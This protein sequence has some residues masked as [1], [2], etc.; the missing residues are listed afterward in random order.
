MEYLDGGTLHDRLAAPAAWMPRTR[1]EWLERA[2]YALDQAHALGSSRDVSPRTCSRR[3][4]DVT[5]FGIAS[6]GGFDTLTLPGTVLGTAGY[7][8]PE[9]AQGEPATPASDLYGLGVVAFELLTGRRP[10]AAETAATEAFAHVNAPVPSALVRQALPAGLGAV[11]RQ[12]LARPR[13][14]SSWRTALVARRGARGQARGHG[15]RPPVVAPATVIDARVVTPADTPNGGLAETVLV[16]PRPPSSPPG[17]R[18][19]LLSVSRATGG[20]GSHPRDP[21]TAAEGSR[22][23]D[24]GFARMQQV[25]ER[26]YPARARGRRAA[27]IG[28]SDQAYARHRVHALRARALHGRARH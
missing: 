20:S 26:R 23:N 25:T 14:A 5:D 17:S 16:A 15:A 27:R 12:A 10:Y 1:I 22:L 6:A 18:S 3:G 24:L 13:R 9:Q 19:P 4:K 28:D 8:S 21:A 2:A 11:F 7:L